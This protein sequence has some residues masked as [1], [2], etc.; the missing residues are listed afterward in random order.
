VPLILFFL[1]FYHLV[2]YILAQ[3]SKAL[4][5]NL[6]Q[7][8]AGG[9]LMGSV[10]GFDKGLDIAGMRVPSYA[11]GAGLGVLGSLAADIAHDYV[12]PYVSKDDRL[13]HIE[14]VLVAP[15]VSAGVFVAGLQLL[16]PSVVGDT[17][18]MWV[19]LQGAGSEL[20]AQWVYENMLVPYVSDGY[21]ESA[22]F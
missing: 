19:L 15:A 16:N 5:K 1:G 4:Y 6:S 13:R 8:A 22:A 14:G 10:V 12:L 11:I 3:M 17:G 2:F 7:A 20:A 21:K 18:L 9:L